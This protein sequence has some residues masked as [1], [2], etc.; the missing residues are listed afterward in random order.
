MR[1]RAFF[2]FEL[3]FLGNHGVINAMGVAWGL[4]H[5]CHCVARVPELVFSVPNATIASVYESHISRTV[6][7]TSKG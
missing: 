6:A 2:K 4:Q 3:V 7:S 1:S 5:S